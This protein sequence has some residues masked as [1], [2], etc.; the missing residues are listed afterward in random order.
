M[1]NSIVFILLFVVAVAF[2]WRNV[3][4]ISRNIKLGKDLDRKD[5]PKKYFLKTAKI[6]LNCL[7]TLKSMN[8]I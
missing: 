5:N 2:F 1:I 8:T 3:K 6:I 7:M 4:K